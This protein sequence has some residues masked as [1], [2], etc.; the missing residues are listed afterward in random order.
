[1][2]K[3]KAFTKEFEEEAV[4]LALT[5]GRRPASPSALNALVAS[6]SP[7]ES[8]ARQPAPKLPRRSQLSRSIDHRQWPT[9][10]GTGFHAAKLVADQAMAF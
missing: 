2:S 4:R 3:Q 8:I 5:S 6:L 10:N 7:F 9:R 1:M